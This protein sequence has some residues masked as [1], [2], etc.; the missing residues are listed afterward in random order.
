MKNKLSLFKAMVMLCLIALASC[1]VDGTNKQ[2][3]NE[4]DSVVIK[5]EAPAS[6]AGCYTMVIEKDS[7]ELMLRDSVGVLTGTLE[8]N[9]FEKDDNTGTFTGHITPKNHLEGWYRFSSEGMIS[10]RQVIFNIANKELIEGYGDMELTHDTA[11][12][13]YPSNLRYEENHPFKKHPCN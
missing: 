5:T 13:K 2:E 3:H 7:A 1:G 4:V 10:V 6:L 8:Y 11:R 12:F 9:R